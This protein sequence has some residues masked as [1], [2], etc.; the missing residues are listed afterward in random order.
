[1]S[2]FG[3]LPDLALEKIYSFFDN[4]TIT[5]ASNVCLS[6]RQFIH[7]KTTPS[8]CD[9]DLMDKLAKC[10]WTMNDAHDIEKL[11]LSLLK[12][13][14]KQPPGFVFNESNKVASCVNEAR[15]DEG[16]PLMFDTSYIRFRPDY[17]LTNSK[18][19]ILKDKNTIVVTHLMKKDKTEMIP[20]D[21]HLE[22]PKREDF[23]MII[24]INAYGNLVAVLEEHEYI[25][26]FY[27]HEGDPNFRRLDKDIIQL[28]NLKK[29]HMFHLETL[30]HVTTLNITE[31]VKL[32]YINGAAERELLINIVEQFC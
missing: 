9:S 4:E 28:D 19:C 11:N 32:D 18:I 14:R 7:E 21:S 27:P 1:M 31:Q 16:K 15:D 24:S 20:L 8:K 30:E 29:L 26:I 12:F 6:W 17:A 10:G 3:G 23:K 2:A 13:V 22:D 25:P 5:N